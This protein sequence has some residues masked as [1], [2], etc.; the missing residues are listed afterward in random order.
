MGRMIELTAADGF[1]LQAYRADPAGAAK[2][3][4][5]VLQEIFGA[6]AHIR[7]VAD[8]LAAAG[9]LA[10]APALFDRAQKHVD[11][12]YGEAAAKNGMALVGKIDRAA[13]MKDVAAAVAAA[14]QGGK[15]GVVGF[16]WG[17]TLAWAAA[18]E[19]PALSA[20]V[21]Y[22]GGGVVGMKALKPKAP[23]MLHFGEKDAGIPLAGIEEV[24]ALHPALPIYVYPG[25]GHA[26]N[27]DPDPAKYHAEAARLAWTRTLDFLGKCLQPRRTAAAS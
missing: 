9:Y 2:G 14:S 4:V 19:T 18:A 6:N 27:R 17:G 10:I 5:V 26:F 16:C 20:A 12:A 23:V 21:G 7:A 13:T 11:W 8:R 24:K 15:V 22:Y 25:A 3:G 1:E